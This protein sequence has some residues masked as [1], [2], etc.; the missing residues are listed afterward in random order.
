MLSAGGEHLAVIF[1][2]IWYYLKKIKV[3]SFHLVSIKHEEGLQCGTAEWRQVSRR[4]R[5]VQ[6]ALS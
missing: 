3:F 5:G 1:L 6:I 4:E 2:N